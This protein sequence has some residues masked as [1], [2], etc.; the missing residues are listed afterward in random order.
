MEDSDPVCSERS[1]E[2]GKAG[3][4]R[5]GVAALEKARNGEPAMGGA[6]AKVTARAGVAHG[7]ERRETPIEH[8]HQQVRCRNEMCGYLAALVLEDQ[9][10]SDWA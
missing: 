2:T 6:R 8:Q 4:T 3:V 9:L 1:P 5:T 7:S 10:T